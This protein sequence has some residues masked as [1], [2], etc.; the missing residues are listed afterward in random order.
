M[1][2]S[3]LDILVAPWTSRVVFTAVR[4]KIFTILSSET[5]TV[6]DIASRC[7]AVPNFLKIL[8]DAC[9]SMKLMLSRHG[10]YMN[11]HLSQVYLVEGAPKYV[12]DFIDLQISLS[13]PVYPFNHLR[14]IS[15][16][17]V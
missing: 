5:M 17:L 1:T 10:N 13:H 2:N 6:E 12:G 14:R 3:I 4:L 11:S 15:K 8:L 9:V 7:G 16:N